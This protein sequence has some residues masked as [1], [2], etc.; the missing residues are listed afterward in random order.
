MVRPRVPIK[1]TKEEIKKEL[2]LVIINNQTMEDVAGILDTTIFRVRMECKEIFGMHMS[3]LQKK[4]RNELDG[5]EIL[6]E[7]E[8]RNYKIVKCCKCGKKFKTEIDK[9]GVAY[10]MRCPCCTVALRKSPCTNR[11][12]WFRGAV[13]TTH[14]KSNRI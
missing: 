4:Y 3:K 6:E 13:N 8:T 11:G 12:S 5:K 7:E 10:L 1:A 9:M 2:E 14:C